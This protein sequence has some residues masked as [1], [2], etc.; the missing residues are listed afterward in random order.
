MVNVFTEGPQDQS[1]TYPIGEALGGDVP[2]VNSYYDR[3]ISFWFQN[4]YAREWNS[5]AVT[6]LG[7]MKVDCWF[8]FN[9][10]IYD[11]I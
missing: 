9:L 2:M 7:C 6:E 8:C 11:M 1:V 10:S 3:I 4:Y 5:T